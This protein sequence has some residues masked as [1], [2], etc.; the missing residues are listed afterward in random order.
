[1]DDFFSI[2]VIGLLTGG[3]GIVGGYAVGQAHIA[4]DCKDFGAF[5]HG[6]I[7]ECKEKAK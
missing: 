4:D 2:I 3:V 6:V 5:K 1:M 7:Y